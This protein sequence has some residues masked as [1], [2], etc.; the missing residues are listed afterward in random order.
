VDGLVS[1]LFD[2]P[3]FV[4]IAWEDVH[5]GWHCGLGEKSFTTAYLHHP[6]DMN[7]S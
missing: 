5:S 4:S 1:H 7:P 6:D 2:D 3:R